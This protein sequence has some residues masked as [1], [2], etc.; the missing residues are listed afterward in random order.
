MIALVPGHS[1]LVSFVTFAYMSLV[2]V[3]SHATPVILDTSIS[4]YKKLGL[5][6]TIIKV[7]I[8]VY[9]SQQTRET[10]Q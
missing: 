3:S 7:F 4:L 5:R 9:F 2:T 8:L 10:S 1:I 6:K